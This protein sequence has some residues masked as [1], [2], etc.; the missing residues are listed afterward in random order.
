VPWPAEHL[1]SPGHHP[2][3]KASVKP[4]TAHDLTKCAITV[5][6][7]SNYTHYPISAAVYATYTAYTMVEVMQH[8]NNGWPLVS[9]GVN[10]EV[11]IVATCGGI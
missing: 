6:P 3:L 7:K 5:T 4:G 9:E 8:K 10:A 11:S 1:L 2:G